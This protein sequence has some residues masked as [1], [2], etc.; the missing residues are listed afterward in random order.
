MESVKDYVPQ[1]RTFQESSLW[2][3]IAIFL[4]YPIHKDTTRMRMYSDVLIQNG[5]AFCYIVESLGSS[6]EII[7]RGASLQPNVISF[8]VVLISTRAPFPTSFK[9]EVG[10]GSH[11]FRGLSLH[12][13]S[14]RTSQ[15]QSLN[16]YVFVPSDGGRSP[17]VEVL[18]N[19]KRYPERT[20]CRR[21]LRWSVAGSTRSIVKLN[22]ATHHCLVRTDNNAPNGSQ[23]ASNG[24]S[25][26]HWIMLS[27]IELWR[28]LSYRILERSTCCI[29]E[30]QFCAENDGVT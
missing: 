18:V 13:C 29:G 9:K 7:G 2:K 19:K 27:S 10:E 12:W 24:P 14:D 17:V 20:D 11:K 1:P 23:G 30:F 25:V 4:R 21:N 3:R 22:S 5:N 16:W 28:L 8:S 6:D 26:R 15:S